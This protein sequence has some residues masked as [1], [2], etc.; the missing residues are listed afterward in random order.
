MFTFI[1]RSLSSHVGNPAS[2]VRSGV[3]RR[4]LLIAVMLIVGSLVVGTGQSANAAATAVSVASPNAAVQATHITC[5]YPWNPGTGLLGCWIPE[6]DGSGD[7]TL[8][9][10]YGYGGIYPC[11]QMYYMAATNF[12]ADWINT[13]AN[14]I[15][16]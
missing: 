16:Q 11:W 13:G 15:C 2:P 1:R 9:Y 12:M 4:S 3:R 7:W 6:T 14:S 10:P 8:A 5:N